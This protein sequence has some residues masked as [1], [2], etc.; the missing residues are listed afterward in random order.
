VS[1][2]I[3]ELQKKQLCQFT[4]DVSDS[5]TKFVELTKKGSSAVHH[6][7]NIADA[8]VSQALEQLT[9]EEREDVVEDLSLY[10]KALRKSRVKS[11]CVIKELKKCDIPKITTITRRVWAEFGFDSNH[12]NAHIY[13]KELQSIYESKKLCYFVVFYDQELIGGGG[14]S[15]I[16]NEIMVC[17]L[18]SMYFLPEF[19]GLGLGSLFL[20]HLLK[21]AKSAGFQKCYLETMDF[22]Q[23]AN[24]LYLKNGFIPLN[25]PQ[26]NTGHIWTNCWYLKE[27]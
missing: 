9:S 12:P 5:R 15:P 23:R 24:F 27:I 16:D 1:R 17:E 6:I 11:L 4:T 26:F 10:A 3:K 7:N 22:M 2:L 8:Q 13:E 25:N 18:R 21:T 14:F 20:S 19:R